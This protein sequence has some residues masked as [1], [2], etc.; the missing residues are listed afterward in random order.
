[1]KIT[2]LLLFTAA[3]LLGLSARLVAAG[4][5]QDPQP[6]LEEVRPPVVTPLSPDERKQL[7]QAKPNPTAT[8]LREINKRPV[9][10]TA[11][12]G[13]IDDQLIDFAR[14]ANVNVLADSNQLDETAP[15]SAQTEPL[16]L[17]WV[18]EAFATPRNLT[19]KTQDGGCFLF[20]KESDL[21][22]IATMIANGHGI[23]PVE[24]P[25]DD[26]SFAT[27]LQDYLR[28]SYNG[29]ERDRD[30]TLAIKLGDL[31]ANLRRQVVAKAQERLIVQP[32]YAMPPRLIWF[33]DE[34]WTGARMWVR[35]GIQPDGKP[36][37]HLWVVLSQ[38]IDG[39]G[40]IREGTGA[41]WL[42]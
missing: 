40:T 32:E 1:M 30:F 24:P 15:E 18:I 21:T 42:P 39:K 36:G 6:R 19:W 25:L 8:R 38:G 3:L 2:T 11:P 7:E 34:S 13:T 35:K 31:P 33:R 10:F 22:S 23:K 17:G 9:N 26:R 14:A 5:Y 12:A 29:R 37:K 20:W 4:P 16:P 28:R 27:A 41:G